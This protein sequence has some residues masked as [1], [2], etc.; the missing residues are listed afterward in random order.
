[1]TRSI[2]RIK[3]RSARGATNM[4]NHTIA[5]AANHSICPTPQR[6]RQASL[7][8]PVEQ[9]AGLR[10]NTCEAAEKEIETVAHQEDELRKAFL[11]PDADEVK[12]SFKHT[13]E[14][15]LQDVFLVESKDKSLQMAFSTSIISATG[16]QKCAL[17][18]KPAASCDQH[19]KRLTAAT[20]GALAD[21]DVA[22]P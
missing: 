14:G 8:A 4:A 17:S 5:M 3:T 21:A 16:A 9:P 6:H 11:P 18:R 12:G 13:S 20:A 10:G 22:C 19:G 7:T 1:M 15:P 2:Q